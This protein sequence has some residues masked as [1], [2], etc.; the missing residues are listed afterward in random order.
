MNGSDYG[1]IPFLMSFLISFLFAT[2]TQK[3]GSTDLK[4]TIGLL[5]IIKLHMSY[6]E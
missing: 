4:L 5:E 2:H 6:P 1:K 3:R